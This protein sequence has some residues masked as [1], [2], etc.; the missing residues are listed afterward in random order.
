MNPL[1]FIAQYLKR[2]RF[3]Y[4]AGITALFV[5]DFAN[6]FI[7][8]LTG[9]ITDGLTAHTMDWNGVKMCLLSIFALGLTLAIGRFLWRFFLFGAART[10]EMELRNDMFA[11]LEKMGVE[12]YNEHKTGD[13]MTR[14]TS[15]LNAIRM[16][17]GPAVISTFDATVM[18]V[19]VIIQMMFY[20]N[21][22]LTLMA[23]VPMILIC[24]G[25]LY[26]GKIIFP[27]YRERQ[28]AVSDLTDYVQESISGVRVVKA[29]VQERAQMR[30]FAKANKNTMDKNL[31]VVRLQAIVMPLL[32]V[33]IGLS[34]LVTLIYGGYLAMTGRISLGRFVAFN[35]YINMLVWPMLACGDAI[36]MFSQGGASIKRVQEIFR[37]RPE[38]RDKEDV[39]NV[40]HIQGDISLS[41]LTFTHKGQKN[42]T[43]KDINLDVKAGT[44]LA[45]IGRTGTGKSTLVNLLLH[46]FNVEPGMIAIDGRDINKIPIKTLRENIA[47][48]P[49]DNFLFSDTLKANIAFGTEG[50]DMEEIVKATE[51]ACIHDN[52]IAFPEGYE[53]VVGER[54]V[55]L[56]GGQKQRSS[57]A[58]ALMKNA[59]ILILDDALSAVDTDTEEKIL[60]NLKRN[61]AGKT[62]ILI[63][64]RISTIQ[65]AD[66][67]M[68]LEDGEAKEIGSHSQLMEQNGIYRE[69]FEMQQLEAAIGEK[70]AVLEQDVEGRGAENT[71]ETSVLQQGKGGAR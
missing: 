29:F 45:I 54:G 8:K 11:H 33:I 60:H 21:V 53:T 71:R 26:F 64:H 17:I 56:S 10:I 16:A 66:V 4:A 68:V 28:E 50:E 19:M 57:I 40:D 49:Q 51:D 32:D 38:V 34:S 63:A 47:Y 55:T 35:Q 44:T 46:L 65:N 70:R 15:D 20:V 41:H 18:T 30:E 67:I 31:N 12:Y 23:L 59:P 39:E 58:R 48:V 13:L 24:V 14:F 37:V 62:T 22:K 69:M 1:K 42:P 3:Q 2:H 6:I 52:I 7:P 9:T 36:N 43:L 25:E 61:R 27:R 5:V